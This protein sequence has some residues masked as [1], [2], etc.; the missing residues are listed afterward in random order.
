VNSDVFLVEVFEDPTA[1]ISATNGAICQGETLELFSNAVNT[2]S[3]AWTGPNGFTSN[4]ADITLP[5]V[6]DLDNGT[7]TVV[8]TSESGCT[9][10][11]TFV[12][13]NITELPVTPTLVADE[14]TCD[15]SDLVLSTTAVGTLFEWISPLG[16]SPSNSGILELTTTTGTTTI[17]PS[18]SVYLSGAWSVRV[19]DANGCTATSNA[20]NLSI[21]EIP[22]ALIVKGGD[23]CSGESIMLSASNVAG[24]NYFWYDA[25]PSAGGIL[26]S[27]DESIELSGLVPNAYT[28]F[29]QIEVDG[30]QSAIVQ[31]T[32]IVNELPAA[33]PTFMYMSN[34][35][36]SAADL[37]LV[38][39]E[40]GNGPFTYNWTGPNGFT[41]TD[42]N[43][44]LLGVAS[45]NNGSYT[46]QIT[47]S[48]GC[49]SE[50]M[51]LEV[52]GIEDSVAEPVIVSSG[53]AC[54]GESI[55][56]SVQSYVGNQVTYNWTTPN[57]FTGIIGQSSNTIIISPVDE[58]LHAG[59]FSVEVIVDDCTVTSD[60]FQVEI[61]ESPTVFIS[62][63]TGAICQGE[64]LELFSNATNAVS[65]AW[66]GPNGFTSSAA[67]V[68][69]P[70]VTDLVNGTYTLTVTSQSGCTASNSF[71]VDNITEL[72]TTPT[73]VVADICENESLVLSTS[74]V[75][76]LFEWISPLGDSPNNSGIPGLITNTGM[77]TIPVTSAAYLSGDWTVRV[78]DANGC[79]STSA[80]NSVVIN[81]I[82]VALARNDGPICEDG[83]DIQLLG[84]EIP[85][86]TYEWYLGD[87]NT[88]GTLISTDM[89]PT[90]F[91]PAVDSVFYFLVVTQDGCS[92]TPSM[93]EVQVTSPPISDPLAIY[94]LNANCALTDLQL[95]S[96]A[97]GTGPFEFL[98]TGPNNFV[99]TEQNPT[100]ANITEAG[101]GSYSVRIIDAN[102]CE[103]TST[104]ELNNISDPQA[105]PVISTSGVSCDDGQIV[106][107]T[108]AYVGTSVTYIWTTPNG[109]V[110]D[111]SGLE[112]NEITISPVDVDVHDG[113]YSLTVIVDDCT[114][115]SATF[116]LEV[117]EEPVA[118]SP[119]AVNNG[120]CVGDDILLQSAVAN[121]YL[122]SGPNGFSS[123]LQFPVISSPSLAAAGTYFLTVFNEQGCQ[124]DPVSIDITVDLQPEQPTVV[125]NDDVI[126]NTEDI[127]LETSSVC[128][129]YQWIGPG[130][131]SATTLN[132]PL[133]TTNAN[134]TSIPNSDEAYARGM[135]SVICINGNGCASEQSAALMVEIID[136]Q[137]PMPSSDQFVACASEE[138]NLSAGEGYAPG[139]QFFW[140][141]NDPASGSANLISNLQ[142]PSLIEQITAGSFTYYL[143]IEQQ[144]CLSEPVP[145]TVEVEEALQ[146]TAANDGTECISSTT[147][148][149]LIGEVFNGTAPFSFNWTGPNN[150]V[151]VQANA[152][153]PNAINGFSG[154][155]ILTV[156]D[157]NGCSSVTETT[158][159]VTGIPVEPVLESVSQ[160]CS[161]S[162]FV[163]SAPLYVGEDVSYFWT[164][165]NGTTADGTYPEGNEIVIPEVGPSDN[166]DYE[167]F[168]VVDG[169]ASNPSSI[170]PVFINELPSVAPDNDGVLCADVQNDL[171]LAANVTGGQ[172][173]Y[174]FFW[175]GPNNFVSQAE[176]PQLSNLGIEASGTYT[177]YVTDSN[178]CE[179]V[180]SS[181][182]VSVSELPAT[183]EL[184]VS[185]Q[186]LCTNEQL[187]L[188]TQNYNSS[189]VTYT[190]I[191]SDGSIVD[192]NV[193]VLLIDGVNATQHD[194]LISVMV[195]VNGCTSFQ[196]T[197]VLVSVSE[198]P[199]APTIANS[200]G[201]SDPACEG[202]NIVLSTPFILDATYTWFGPNGFTSNLPSPSVNN[203]ALV[204]T[205]MYFL[206]VEING[207]S[208]NP[209]QT[210]VYIEESPDTP[211]AENDGPYCSQMEIRLFVPNP[212]PEVLY[213]WYRASN[214]ALVGSGPILIFPAASLSDAGGY[215]VIAESESCESAQSNVT[216]VVVNQESVAN[217][218]AG[219][220]DIV[221]E[222]NYIIT[223]NEL[224]DGA[225][226]W[227]QVNPAGQT[228]IVDPS[229]AE[230]L[231]RNLE[232]G[233]N[234][235]VWTIGNGACM[236]QATDTLVIVYNDDPL[237]TDD[238]YALEVNEFLDNSVLNN[239]QA[240]AADFSINNFTD[241][242]NGTL[243]QNSDGTFTYQPNENFVGTDSYSYELCHTFCPENCVE[244]TVFITI[245]EEAECFAPTIMTPNGD[246]VNDTFTIPCL[247]NYEGSHMC[248][249]NRWGDE[250][251]RNE[252]YRNEWDGTYRQDGN[253]LPS[254]TYFYILQ[255]NDGNN[256][257]L[258]GY[259]FIER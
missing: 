117:L 23:V 134:T 158:V 190:W 193:P 191:L 174:T 148:V 2:V 64:T 62:A 183:P 135:W 198:Q 219:E 9:A 226:F 127:V 251:Y 141:D 223:G 187:V 176:N 8:V 207:C 215:Y 49:V 17:V 238:I 222:P 250:V 106:L 181:T 89:S 65:Y 95:E 228:Q 107:S 81:D 35:D 139:T 93:T 128:D 124:S 31:S 120:V 84:N 185:T 77:T 50:L 253:S 165:P 171:N 71:V 122:W 229:Q 92:S 73:L 203:V 104:V 105:Q 147:D 88:G 119:T 237:A 154:T 33:G 80:V 155:Y 20:L 66:T 132:N 103:S 249:F 90:L 68:T 126:C 52:N 173:P 60:A 57:G 26:I 163:I 149:N 216:E 175:S 27:Q 116:N 86:A 150:F 252:N 67:D 258:N 74:A 78:T 242:E 111:I 112:T 206:I 42:Q 100:I 204:D 101:N 37:S 164:G 3:Y 99:S 224:T 56:L 11:N 36:C 232:F 248:I 125:V 231:V 143:Q 28:Y 47:D 44:I 241:P 115:N 196:A 25:D 38:A 159:D 205:G 76:T 55:T 82:P 240:N 110:Q 259:I 239:D 87:P 233:E 32:A 108:Q 177:L 243:I 230:T 169:C 51:A 123:T 98:W 53:S 146:I 170:M 188:T 182:T 24:A 225:G 72:P 21:N 180:I 13:D 14:I 156:T 34:V 4:A 256:T 202:T 10:T 144:G 136:I 118:A 201:I 213:N 97:I 151:S 186:Q 83:G 18:S 94:N 79:T 40:S 145:V 257:V 200:T 212:N 43:P 214:N 59:A 227:T 137:D 254:G 208:S 22:E 46:V 45:V 41:S 15:G 121:E 130:G 210:Q 211:V 12:V 109:T 70:E 184:E 172:A 167:V 157:A 131:S 63:T 161:G 114:V 75:G 199:N 91:A 160:L 221:C 138:V 29:L 255:I 113:D 152:I 218:Y 85:G 168:V 142:N 197:P 30:C 217:A 220:D 178:G 54:N 234:I 16:D 247:S 246:G 236:N 179:S 7:Y 102:G 6:T 153:L 61:F 189:N 96:N 235:F 129:T 245:G 244:A 162:E 194:G 5:G 19:T 192:T 39:N 69:L 195:T 209:S 166:G 133:L 48:N 58:T 1:L 140:Y